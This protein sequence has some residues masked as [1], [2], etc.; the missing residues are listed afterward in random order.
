MVSQKLELWLIPVSVLLM[1]FRWWENYISA[2]SVFRPIRLLSRIKEKLSE[3]RYYMHLFISLWKI[4]LILIM[5]IG[6]SDIEIEL[7]FTK[8]T[9]GWREHNVPIEQVTKN[10]KLLIILL[11]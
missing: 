1:S 8:F 2:N 3:S 4:C 5:A 7:F 11:T 9:D 6:L 10:L